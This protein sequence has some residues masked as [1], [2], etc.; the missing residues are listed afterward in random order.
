MERLEIVRQARELFLISTR[1]YTD[2]IAKVCIFG[3]T[4]YIVSPLGTTPTY[5]P[6]AQ[7][8]L[9]QLHETVDAIKE[10]VLQKYN[11]QPNDL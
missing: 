2:A 4:G 1:P 7:E 8:A 5:T 9:R 3:C 10:W 11:L 6:E